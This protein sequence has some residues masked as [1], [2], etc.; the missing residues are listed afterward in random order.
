MNI[1]VKSKILILNSNIKCYFLILSSTDDV[2]TVLPDFPMNISPAARPVMCINICNL[3]LPIS[4]ADLKLQ[5]EK[6]MD[7]VVL[8]LEHNINL[9]PQHVFETC[10]EAEIQVKLSQQYNDSTVQ[11]AHEETKIQDDCRAKGKKKL[12][13]SPTLCT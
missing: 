8:K 7:G 10:H 5:G 13:F 3:Q 6:G 1:S 2:P 4:C 11:H 12:F 9:R